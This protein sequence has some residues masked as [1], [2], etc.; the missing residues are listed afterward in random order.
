MKFVTESPRKLSIER[1]GALAPEAFHERFLQGS[2]KPAIVT[3]AMNS[4]K[5]L[6]CWSFDLFKQRYGSD[7]VTPRL[8]CPRS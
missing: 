6:S 4:W 5:A 2:G 3:G 7:Q 8:F 1:T